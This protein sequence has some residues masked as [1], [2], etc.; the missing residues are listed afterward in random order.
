[1]A[2]E[3]T[4]VSYNLHKGRT[5]MGRNFEFEGLQNI[6]DHENFEIGFFQEV[7]G[8]HQSNQDLPHQLELL[9]GEKWHEYSFAKNSVVSNFEH[10]NAI[11]SKYPIIEEKYLDLTLNPLE[12]RNAV[13]ALIDIEGEK[14]AAICTHLNLFERQR[15][16]QCNA[17]IDFIKNEVPRDVPLILAGDFND[18]RGS[19]T[20]QL[21]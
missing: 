2:R 4:A 7:L 11:L 13:Y 8:N 14:F 9:A 3:L 17:L 16:M 6:L 18:W 15:K 5:I 21:F 1:M 10:G 12:K 19:I 20:R